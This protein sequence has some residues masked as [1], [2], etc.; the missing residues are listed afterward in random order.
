MASTEL[1]D[2]VRQEGV[3]GQFNQWKKTLSKIQAVLADAEKKQMETEG[4]KLW[5]EDLQDLAY[6]LDDLVDDFATEVLKRKLKARAQAS[7]SKA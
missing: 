5:L 2:F 7:T 4:V 6:H 1:W 3:E